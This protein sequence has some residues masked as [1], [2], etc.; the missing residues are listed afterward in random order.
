MLGLDF[1]VQ[2]SAEFRFFRKKQK[3]QTDRLRSD[4]RAVFA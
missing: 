1:Y 3:M 4:P 2:M